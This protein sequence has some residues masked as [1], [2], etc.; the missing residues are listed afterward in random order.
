LSSGDKLGIKAAYFE[1]Y[2][3]DYIS[4]GGS[5]YGTPACSVGTLCFVNFNK[6]TYKGIELSGNYDAGTFFASAALNYYTEAGVGNDPNQLLL[7]WGMGY[8][9][10]KY[11]M[12]ATAGVRLF[13]QRLTLGTRVRHHGDRAAPYLYLPP[14]STVRFQPNV[15]LVDLFGNYAFNDSVTFDFS[16]ENVTDQYYVD[17][18]AVA[19]IPSPGRTARVGFTMKLG[20][21]GVDSRG[22]GLPEMTTPATGYNWSGAFA[23]LNVGYSM[24]EASSRGDFAGTIRRSSIWYPYAAAADTSHDPD[25]LTAGAYAGYN[26]QLNS[27]LVIGIDGSIGESED[28]KLQK[29]YSF[30]AHYIRNG[31]NTT[32]PLNTTV[33]ASMGWHADLRGRLGVAFDRL[34]PYVAGGL[35]VA[36]FSYN[37]GAFS[38]PGYTNLTP[39][40]ATVPGPTNLKDVFVGWTLGGGIEHA[41][42][43][44]LILRAEYRRNDFGKKT[45]DTAGGK[46]EVQLKSDEWK[47]G[48][49][50]KF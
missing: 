10:P 18:L 50:Y 41:M 2:Y 22:P 28:M 17:P 1:N 16:M 32:A 26:L 27:P 14:Y 46:H 30:T 45:F 34:L 48:I 7:Q 43:D 12:S 6:I 36:D 4:M 19:A 47:L 44:K 40:G 11:T 9:P 39:A 23:G 8:V 13:D 49:A 35:M 5:Y 20:D 15:T 42:T 31:V 38:I 29:A 37:Y 33:T 25:S 21:S 24:A 3:T